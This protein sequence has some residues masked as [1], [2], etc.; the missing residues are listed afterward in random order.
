MFAGKVEDLKA[1]MS[2]LL[3]G[4]SFDS[5]EVVEAK[6]ETFFELSVNGRVKKSFFDAED[7]ITREF[8]S[9]KEIKE[10]FYRMIKGKRLPGLLRI[11]LC[12]DMEKTEELRKNSGA[13][14]LE[15]GSRLLLNIRY[16]NG[17]CIV[18]GGV[19]HQSFS[20]D[21]SLEQAWDKELQD[22]LKN[23]GIVVSTHIS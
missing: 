15:Q 8:V 19:S 22:I 1:F 7:E 18:T 13:D 16:S 5:W 23:K 20:L 9:W 21:K 17:E 6:A 12:A 10:L 14:A 4:E 3:I 2:A 11:V